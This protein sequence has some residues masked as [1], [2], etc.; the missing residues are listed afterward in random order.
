MPSYMLLNQKERV[1]DRFDAADNVTA[2]GIARTKSQEIQTPLN[3]VRLIATTSVAQSVSV[4]VTDTD[5]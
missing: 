4:N 3:L 5:V 2:K 1:I